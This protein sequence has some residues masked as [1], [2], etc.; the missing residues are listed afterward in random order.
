MFFEDLES[1]QMYSTTLIAHALTPVDNH[2]HKV[3]A[4]LIVSAAPSQKTPKKPA[5]SIIAAELQD[6]AN[7]FKDAK[8]LPKG[9]TVLLPGGLVLS[10][11][12]TRRVSK[13]DLVALNTMSQLLGQ[14]LQSSE[15]KSLLSQY[16]KSLNA[17]MGQLSSGTDPT[18]KPDLSHQLDAFIADFKANTDFARGDSQSKYADGGLLI[19]LSYDEIQAAKAGK[20]KTNDKADKTEHKPTTGEQIVEGA[21]EAGEAVVELFVEVIVHLSKLPGA[22]LIEGPK[23]LE[24]SHLHGDD[25]A[26]GTAAV[27]GQSGAKDPRMPRGLSD[28]NSDDVKLDPAAQRSIERLWAAIRGP[29]SMPTFHDLAR[30]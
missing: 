14:A 30:R 23:V 26:N 24:K 7:K 4:D 11:D 27:A 12:P 18:T 17:M 19:D 20:T 3:P 8:N 25:L 15:L 22:D 10:L 1:R 13:D 16:G 5:S 6:A 2:K 9:G 21:K 29:K 28:P